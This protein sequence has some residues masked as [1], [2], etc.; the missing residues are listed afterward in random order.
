MSIYLVRH[1]NA[2]AR[3]EGP[4][5]LLRP[6]DANGQAM[7]TAIAQAFSSVKVDAIYSSRALRC[8]QTVAPLAAER[9]LRIT[10]SNEITEGASISSTLS[11]IRSLIGS[12]A[13]VCSHG[14]VIPAILS[15][16]VRDGMLVQG[17]RG[18]QKGSVWILE[19]SGNDIVAGRYVDH[20]EGSVAFAT[21]LEA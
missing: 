19:T 20:H 7:A 14:D 11:W 8:I 21:A 16:L 13:V 17:Q 18:C 2:G 10:E 4:D 6:L 9:V 12:E 5:D 15:V 3:R 1:A